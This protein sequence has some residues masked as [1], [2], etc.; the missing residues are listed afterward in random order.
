MD[1]E[2][3]REFLTSL[4]PDDRKV[5]YTAGDGTEVSAIRT[6]E[7]TINDFSIGLK[8]PDEQE[9]NSTFIRLLID[10]HLKKISNPDESDPLCEVFESIYEGEDC[11]PLIEST[12]NKNFPMQL[13]GLDINMVCAQLLMIKREF[14]YGPGKRDTSY[15]PARGYLMAFIRWVL[16]EKN[17]IDKIVTAAVKEYMP[18]KQFDKNH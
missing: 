16:S 9:F 2:K 7:L 3:A 12:R 10:L 13:D 4:S 11:T 6:D 1:I 18:P 5:F 17:E 14:N 8:K 15:N